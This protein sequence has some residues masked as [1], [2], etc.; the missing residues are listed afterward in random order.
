MPNVGVAQYFGGGER[1]GYTRT[2]DTWQ[3]KGTYTKIIGSHTLKFGAEYNIIG[4]F[5]RTNDHSNNFSTVG[6]AS[7]DNPGGTG[8]PLASFL[9]NVPNAWSRRDF[10]KR[11]RGGALYSY[12]AQDSWKV[13]P[14][15]T[16]N[17]GLRL[18]KTVLPQ[19]GNTEENTVEFGNI[20]YNEGIYWLTAAPPTCAVK[21]VAPCLPDSDG[22]LPDR[23]QV[24]SNGYIQ[25]PWPVSWQPRFGFAYRLND[26]TALRAS[27]GVFFD[28]FAGV[29]QNTQNLG[30]TW[31]DVGRKLQN[32]TNPADSI[33]NVSAKNPAPTG[34]LPTATPYNQGA[35]YSD[36]RMDN[37]Y[38]M[39]WNFG[40]QRQLAEDL[41]W[42]V[43]YVGS[44][45][46]RL[47]S[48][49]DGNNALPGP[50]AD[51][52]TIQERRPHPIH[53][54][55][56]SENQSDAVSGYHGLTTK[57]EKRFSKGISYRLN[58]AWSKSIDLNSQWGGTSAQNSLDKRGSIGVS[59]FHRAH[60]FSA[61]MVW[62][63]PRLQSLTGAL[64]KIINNW[65]VNTIVQLRSGSYLTPTLTGDH[66]NVAGRGTSQRPDLAGS[67][68]G[69]P[70][71]PDR[72]VDPASFALPNAPQFVGD[73]TG[74]GTAGRNI[75]EGPGYA[76]V[77]F[78]FYKN[79]P[80]TEHIGA[81]LRFEFFNVFDRVNFNNPGTGGWDPSNFASWGALTSTGDA[82]QIQIAVKFYF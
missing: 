61:D 11:A 55:A 45:G 62:R 46:T 54:G 12:F 69:Y 21:A 27:A 28:N 30:H 63:L 3:Y 70:R 60:I 65:Q 76:G 57:L 37:A 20:D 49:I 71:T 22:T 64:D 9:L 53:T 39:Q 48:F 25:D 51:G 17:F 16:I 2:S 67:A 75:I 80:L 81:Q 14:K 44:K 33:P 4:H 34:I 50:S 73:D 18:D 35:W 23:V 56:F 26:R 32:G 8:H 78:S 43:N 59:D 58:Y 24:A 38:S 10:H 40:I 7:P 29:T 82:R 47:S 77:D 1:I 41:M 52:D 15:L 66:N 72:W 19:F 13:T 79:I 31:P 5:G 74:Y 68:I 42:E 36:P 6:T